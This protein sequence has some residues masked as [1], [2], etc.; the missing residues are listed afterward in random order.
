[1]RAGSFEKLD[2]HVEVDEMFIGGKARCMHKG[3]RARTIY[4]TGG[5]GKVAV[6]G[7]LE[8][9]DEVR[10]MAVPNVRCWSLHGEVSRHVEQGA[11]FSS[12]AL[13]YN[14]LE[15]EFIHNVIK[16]S[17]RSVDGHIH[18]NGIENSWAL[19]KRGLGRTCISVEPVHLFRYLDEQFFRFNNRKLTGNDKFLSLLSARLSSYHPDCGVPTFA[20][21]S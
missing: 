14:R 15:D 19:L 21:E 6:M 7:L 18:A 12:D 9:Q 1:M 8:R 16:H 17:E 10:T 20:P 2:G 5:S 11:M 4:G 3:R 13:A